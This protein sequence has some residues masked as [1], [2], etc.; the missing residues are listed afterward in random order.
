MV[1]IPPALDDLTKAAA[2][3]LAAEQEAYFAANNTYKPS[4]RLKVGE[5]HLDRDIDCIA[6]DGPDGKGYVIVR[7]VTLAGKRY[8]K[9]ENHGPETYRE[10]DWTEIT[11]GVVQ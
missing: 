6:Y 1:V 5:N 2:V 4:E 7:K 3:Q 9:M 10:R 11:S 8:Y